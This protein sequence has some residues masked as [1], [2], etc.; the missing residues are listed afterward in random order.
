VQPLEVLESVKTALVDEKPHTFAD[1]VA[2]ARCHWQEQYSNQ[3]RQLL[4]NFPPDQVTSSGQPFWSGPKRCPDPLM[5]DVNDPLHM[6][7]IVAAANL[8]A[9]V[10]E[11][12]INRDRE[13][14]AEILATVKIPE[15]T[16]K[17][18]VKIAETDSQV[19]NNISNYSS[20]NRQKF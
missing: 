2:W 3:I 8:K 19:K 6:D 17:S 5:F 16:P 12:P 7:Y 15:F 9:K 13:E 1:C 20:N 18:G 14:I 10:Y 4:F 11:I